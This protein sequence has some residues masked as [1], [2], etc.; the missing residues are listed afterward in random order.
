VPKGEAKPPGRRAHHGELASL[1]W[2]LSA[3][4]AVNDA[5]GEAHRKSAGDVGSP[6][7]S[8]KLRNGLFA[9]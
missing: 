7:R 1:R 3:G 4:E 6:T 5:A 2:E 9:E 8:L